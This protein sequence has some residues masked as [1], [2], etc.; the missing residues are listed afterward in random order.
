MDTLSWKHFRA[1]RTEIE[2][3]FFTEQEARDLKEAIEVRI[4]TD[5]ELRKAAAKCWE[6]ETAEEATP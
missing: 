4:V 6:P 3:R 1:V 5:P 2:G